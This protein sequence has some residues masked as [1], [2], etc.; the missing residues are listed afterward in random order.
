M[1]RGRPLSSSDLSM[2]PNKKI[3]IE[4]SPERTEQRQETLNKANNILKLW[5]SL[6]SRVNSED[7]KTQQ[8]GS[9]MASPDHGSPKKSLLRHLKLTKYKIDYAKDYGTEKQVIYYCTKY[10]NDVPTSYYTLCSRA[11]AYCKLGK[12]DRAMKDLNSAI[13]I[14]PQRTNAWYLRGAVKGLKESYTDAIQDLNKAIMIDPNNCSAL[15][16]RAYCYYKL[17]VYEEA[18]CDIKMVIIMGCANESTFINKNIIMRE[19]REIKKHNNLTKGLEV[20]EDN[21]APLSVIDTK[22]KGKAY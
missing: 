20:S 10:L 2:P 21:G 16:C 3:L 19:I 14:K 15:K 1:K 5:K 9:E 17:K 13:L 12:Y 8:P 22:G 18:L 7:S 4:R 6:S 11:D